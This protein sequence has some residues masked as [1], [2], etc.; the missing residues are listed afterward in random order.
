MALVR[1]EDV[2]KTFQ[3][4]GGLVHAVNGVSLGIDRKSV[5]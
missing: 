2:T 4:P 1:L 5:V 3:T